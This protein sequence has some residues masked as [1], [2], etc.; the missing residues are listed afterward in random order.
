[1][2]LLLSLM[3][4]LVVVSPSFWLGNASG[5]D[6]QFHAGSWL[7]AAGQWMHGIL[8]PRWTEWANHGFGEPRFI[9]YPPLS[10]ML[11]AGLGFLVPWEWVPV[12]FIVLVQTFAG[13]SAYLMARRLLPHGAALFGALCYAANPNALLI[14]YLR[15]DFAELLACAFFPLLLLAA[16]QCAGV[17]EERN[18]NHIGSMARFAFLFALIWLCNAPAAVMASYSMALL[19]GCAALMQKSWRGL[20]RGT[21][22]LALGLGLAG[23]YILPAA[24]EQRWVSIGQVL[25]VGLAPVDNFLFTETSDPE[26][27]VFNNIASG[28]AILLIVMTGIASLAARRKLLEVG[29]DNEGARSWWLLL[30]LAALSTL[31]M[32]R[33]SSVAWNILPKLRFIQFPWRFMSILALP[34]SFYLAAASVRRKSRWVWIGTT[35]L[36]LAG[37]GVFLGWQA[38]WDTEDI[39]TLQAGIARGEGFDGTDEYDPIGDDHTN[40]PVK[41]PVVEIIHPVHEHGAISQGRVGVT[42]WTAED[43]ELQVTTRIPLQIALRLLNYPAWR[44]EVNGKVVQPERADDFNQMIVPVPAGTSRVTVRFVR[45]PDRTLGWIIS[46][47]SGAIVLGLFFVGRKDSNRM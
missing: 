14:I 26:H 8:L 22:G 7:D 42:R 4:S 15:S 46:G 11:G 6:V 35:V 18:E 33:L 47:I 39:P 29:H 43:K 27:W 32:M 40:L 28:V 3:V 10:W 21:F 5:H 24:F 23:F 41:A 38:W 44:V 12:V 20:A 31:L 25:S 2:A 13:C 16:L 30:L 1:M 19:F 37:T 36:L 9:F 17:L 45:T 34:F